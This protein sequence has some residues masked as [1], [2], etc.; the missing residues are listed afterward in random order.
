[1]NEYGIKEI[2]NNSKLQRKKFGRQ[3]LFR[4]SYF[5]CN[6]R[7]SQDVEQCCAGHKWEKN[8]KNE[9]ACWIKRIFWELGYELHS[10]EGWRNVGD[11]CCMCYTIHYSKPWPCAIITV[12][13]LCGIMLCMIG[14]EYFPG[15]NLCMGS[16]MM[17]FL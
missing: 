6:W 2:R 16:H 7:S 14:F 13:S 11:S 9:V 12:Q 8:D 10:S 3:N 5:H 4:E 15:S 17:N 1:M